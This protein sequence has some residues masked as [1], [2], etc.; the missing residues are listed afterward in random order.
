M[1]RDP[2]SIPS[3]ELEEAFTASSR[4]VIR[5]AL[6]AQ[7]REAEIHG[8]GKCEWVNQMRETVVRLEEKMSESF[9]PP[10]LRAHPALRLIASEYPA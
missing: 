1:H 8:I 5:A 6:V 2:V 10:C 7:I 9:D 4:R 3:A